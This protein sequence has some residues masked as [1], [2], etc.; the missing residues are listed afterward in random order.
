MRKTAGNHSHDFP[1]GKKEILLFG[2]S[3]N[4]GPVTVY[5]LACGDT[6]PEEILN[7]VT[8]SSVIKWAF[9]A[10]FER[11]CLSVWLRR[12]HP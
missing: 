9:N 10:S 3:I 7:A 1:S 4:S 12:H 5:D 8:D 11:I 2:V 6:I